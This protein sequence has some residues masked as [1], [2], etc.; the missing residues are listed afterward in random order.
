P[1]CGARGFL[2]GLR[3]GGGTRG[4]AHETTLA[5]VGLAP[6]QFRDSGPGDHD[7]VE[8][9]RRLLLAGSLQNDAFLYFSFYG[10]VVLSGGREPDRCNTGAGGL[11]Q[12][13][14]SVGLARPDIENLA[15][16]I[17][18]QPEQ[19]ARSDTCFSQSHGVSDSYRAERTRI[20]IELV[21]R[22]PVGIDGRE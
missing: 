2:L 7:A 22:V 11:N 3:R 8:K 14:G 16:L 18:P 10:A 19:H 12:P 13:L 21:G 20:G 4:G 5:D 17:D 15:V 6:Q 1:R 9:Q